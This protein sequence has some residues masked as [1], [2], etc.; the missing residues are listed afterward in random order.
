MGSQPG[1]WE[2][3]RKQARS[4]END[5]DLKLVAFSKLGTNY[6]STKPTGDKQPLLGGDS[7][8]EDLQ[9]ELDDLLARLGQVNEDM[10]GYAVGVGVGQSAAI[11]HTLQRHT[12]IL[13]DYRQEFKKT[14]SNI[15][16]IV[17]REDLLSSVQ[18]DISDYRNKE[19]G[20]RGQAMDSLQ[21]EM[22]HT[23]NSERLIDEQINIALETRESL[24][25]QREIIKAVQ[26][27]LND[28]T[29]KFPMINNLVS[30]INLRKRRD[31]IILGLVI[32]LCLTAIIWYIFG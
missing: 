17:E 10:S 20:K 7:K 9:G 15:A 12:E 29:N 14:A 30:K 16:A 13:Q 8:L 5:I 11:H 19:N 18:S 23:R 1:N 25:S 4:L 2:G 21:R 24:V 27:K 6:N 32:G 31:T 26:T 3:L 28:I 22:E